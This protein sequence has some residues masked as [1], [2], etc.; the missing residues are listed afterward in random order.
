M[1]EKLEDDLRRL[2]G[3]AAERAPRAPKELPA[4]VVSRSRR[5]RMRTHALVAAV[6]VMVIAG[7]VGVGVRAVGEGAAPAA[8]PSVARTGARAADAP[9]MI[10]RVW[11]EAVWRVPR[12]LAALTSYRPEAFLDDRTLLLT[13]REGSEKVD[14]LYAYGLET[15][16]V[17]R[18]TGIRTPEGVYA[19][20]F[21]VGDG[22]IVYHTIETGRTRFWSVP[23]TGGK[24]EEVRTGKAVLGRADALVVAGNRLAFSLLEGGV[25]TVPLAGGTVTPVPGASR[26]H[27]LSWPWVGTP[28][29]YTP[30]NET[31]FEEVV[32][33]E[34]GQRSVAVVRPGEREVRCGVTTCS[35]DR[36]DGTHFYR[37]RDGS[38][39][40]DL[41]GDPI[42]EVAGDRFLT[43]FLPG[44][45][46][47]AL[48]D[49]A[50]GR[51]GDLGLRPGVE[52]H[53]GTV[54]PGQADGR[55]MAY[56][57]GDEYMIVDLARIR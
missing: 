52:G 23:V 26:H 46:G 42:V 29:S 35:G 45:G 3:E 21:A 53:E 15:G 19:G 5:R 32:N 17:R 31:S 44:G 25:F 54:H 47:Q 30:R 20:G 38:R 12:K 28:G 27:I 11:P 50:T 57:R 41:P 24:P 48:Y 18:I 16:R 6:S 56:E 7:G 43:V 34:T 36:Q 1:S 8:V 2:L 14:A 22:R 40:R 39:E 13:T 49:L 10:D 51:S 9:P 4:Y 37:W 33:V 55:L